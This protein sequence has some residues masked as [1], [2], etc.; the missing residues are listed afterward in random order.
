MQI[1][2]PGFPVISFSFVIPTQ[3]C[4]YRIFTVFL[5][6]WSMDHWCATRNQEVV[7]ET[8]AQFPKTKSLSH[9]SMF[10]VSKQIKGGGIELTNEQSNL[11]EFFVGLQMKS[12]VLRHTTQ[13]GDIFVMIL[14][15][16]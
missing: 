12:I 13:P 16:G 9:A 5:G 8:T 15:S 6:M 10:H 4:E 2:Q 11:Y 7:Y 14:N 3:H 1:C